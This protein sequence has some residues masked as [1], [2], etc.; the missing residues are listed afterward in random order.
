M[1]SLPTLPW[2]LRICM[3]DTFLQ[4]PQHRGKPG[5][6]QTCVYSQNGFCIFPVKLYILFYFKI[7]KHSEFLIYLLSHPLSS[8][9]PQQ[10]TNKNI[11]TKS[12]QSLPLSALPKV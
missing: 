6:C 9:S 1:L 4:K 11:Q 10:K 12:T 7:Q 5:D 2:A 8:P 3:E